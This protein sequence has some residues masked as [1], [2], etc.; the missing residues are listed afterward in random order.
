MSAPTAGEIESALRKKGFKMMG[1][2]DPCE[3]CGVQSFTAWSI[4][5]RT[6]GRQVLWCTSCNHSTSFRVDAHAK[7]VP[8][9]EFKLFPFL[10]IQ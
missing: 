9:P 4:G 7:R 8:D 6:G 2:A 5:G 3:K 1:S 10:G